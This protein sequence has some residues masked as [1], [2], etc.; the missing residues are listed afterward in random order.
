MAN[1]SKLKAWVRYDG[2]GRVVTAGPIFQANK[3]KVGNW[4]QIN[5]SLCCNPSGSTTTT[6]TQGGGSVTPTAFV[7]GYWLTT[8]D[9]CITT[10]AGSLVFY[11]AST[12]VQAGITVFSDAA[13]TTPVTEGYVIYSGPM[14]AETR[15][16]VGTGGLLSVY[17]CPVV[18]YSFQSGWS[19]MDRAEACTY[20]NYATLFA[21]T[22]TLGA[23]VNVYLDN[24]LTQLAPYAYVASGGY[25]YQCVNGNLQT[26]QVCPSQE[27]VVANF[28]P[29][30]CA[31][32]GNNL[33]VYYTGTLG[34]GTTLYTDAGLTVPYD[35]NTYGSYVRM[36]F[37]AGYQL[38]TMFGNTIMNHTAC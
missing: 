12:D 30:A 9:S 20:S 31:G 6:T 3:P 2:T 26:Q 27:N 22:P 7:K 15:Y 14:M 34:D 35:P 23:Y 29:D 24:Q 4:R 5:S 25:S 37:E 28:S 16:L 33:T 38:C 11:S 13:L 1:Q 36:Y 10:L 21:N 8:N 19:Y 17:N 32:I 18:S